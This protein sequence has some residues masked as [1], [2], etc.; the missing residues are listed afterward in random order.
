M[1]GWSGVLLQAD[2]VRQVIGLLAIVGVVVIVLRNVVSSSSDDD[3]LSETDIDDDVDFDFTNEE[4]QQ[5]LH[6]DND[7]LDNLEAQV[8]DDL[9]RLVYEGENESHYAVLDIWWSQIARELGYEPPEEDDGGAYIVA[10]GTTSAYG[11]H[12]DRVGETPEI[13]NNIC[14]TSPF[15]VEHQSKQSDREILNE[16]TESKLL[17][18]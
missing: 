10:L 6:A 13:E 14:G 9:A 2:T 11:N 17:K 8:D 15:I 7:L 3:T 16:R 12:S 18:D 5:V 1:M 4:V